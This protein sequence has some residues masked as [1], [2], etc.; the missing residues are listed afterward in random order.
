M[1][2]TIKVMSFN[3]RT[4]C[5]DDGINYFWNRT[6]RVLN[7]INGENPDVI[8]FQEATSEMRTWLA[9]SLTGYTQQV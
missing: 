8:G 2:D 7:V 4:P 1:N 9:D 5:K 3:L 6:D